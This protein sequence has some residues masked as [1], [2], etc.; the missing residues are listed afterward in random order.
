MSRADK[1]FN[2][3]SNKNSNNKSD[4]NSDMNTESKELE[5]LFSTAKGE[6]DSTPPEGLLERLLN[7]IPEDVS[8]EPIPLA[9]LS[10]SGGGDDTVLPL[11]P[12]DQALPA[13]DLSGDEPPANDHRPRYWLW[14]VAASLILAVGL[15]SVLF[16]YV[17]SSEPNLAVESPSVEI[18]VAENSSRSTNLPAGV[19]QD[20]QAQ[21]QGSASR[22]EGEAQVVRELRSA[23]PVGGDAT[24]DADDSVS[25]PQ[26]VT[27]VGG[28]L[29]RSQDSAFTDG[30]VDEL[31]LRQR[32]DERS[33]PKPKR[34][35]G[36]RKQSSPLTPAAPTKP[37]TSSLDRRLKSELEERD[38]A[39]A[40]APSAPAPSD[41]E[42]EMMMVEDRV[43]VTAE[44]PLIEVKKVRVGAATTTEETNRKLQAL[45]YVSNLPVAVPAPV[46]DRAFNDNFFESVDTN[47]FI[48]T[49]DDQLST[50]GLDVDTGSYSVV[51]EYLR[52]GELPP[53]GAVRVEEMVNYF[54]YRDLPPGPGEGDF[55]LSAEGAPS[56][57]GEGERYYLLRVGVKGREISAEDRAPALLTFVIDVS[58]SMDR[59]NRLELV[60]Q[61]LNLLLDQLKERDRVALVVYGTRGRVL[62]EPTSDR[63]SIRRAIAALRPEGS[64]N[65]GEGLQLAYEMA[66]RSQRR[67]SNGQREINRI[68]L[69]SD[70]VANV[71][72][73]SADSILEMVREHAQ[74]GVEL[75]TVGFGMGNYNDILMEQ[76]ADRGNGRYAYVDTLTEARRIFVENLTGT[77]QTIAAEARAQVEFNPEVISRYRLLGYENRNIADERFR[78]DTVDAGEIG[79]GHT[80]TVLYELKAKGPLRKRDRVATVHLRYAS[81][82]QGEMVEQ[83]LEV[84][85]RDF[86][87]TWQEAPSAFR[88]AALVGELAE[89]LRQ[90]YWAH[91]TEPRDLFI[92]LQKVA[93]ELPGDTKIAELATL[94]GKVADLEQLRRP[95]KKKPTPSDRE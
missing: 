76:L 69:C 5:M 2:K 58:G 71:G 75:T 4:K 67:G 94:A 9:E 82:A 51:R 41:S 63:E 70:G 10:A 62:L 44:A 65:A 15:G 83:Q 13:G 87:A 12:S 20:Q 26:E 77:L 6:V 36:A 48:D 72:K 21:V 11:S 61:S 1:N 30:M 53:R 43:I 85:G 17:D 86:A 78:D 57:Y 25:G 28:N 22:A 80:V 64:T 18:L 90:S 79:A 45:G 91:D 29:A 54:D 37:S 52:R 23:R 55:A 19:K 56:I 33:I 68:I 66:A 16:R 95:E 38:V 93:A 40:P 84:R 3:Y 42:P 74:Q 32:Q 47:P 14:S 31:S 7:D 34:K 35:S 39:L 59:E 81:I 24:R 8:F 49:E 89:V 92:R 60:K 88:L 50:F 73:T 27:V 46:N